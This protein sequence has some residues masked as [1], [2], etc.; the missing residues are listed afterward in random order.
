MRNRFNEMIQDGQ[1]QTMAAEAYGADHGA[2]ACCGMWGATG[3]KYGHSAS[4]RALD[5]RVN[6]VVHIL[7]D[8]DAKDS[9]S[10]GI[11]P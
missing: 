7:H 5:P 8:C 11:V 2:I 10:V 4:A 1:D 9:S 3:R 6:A